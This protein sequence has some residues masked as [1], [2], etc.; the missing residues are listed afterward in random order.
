MF[1]GGLLRI[2]CG[3][4]LAAVLRTDECRCPFEGASRTCG[5]HG[6]ERHVFGAPFLNGETL[7]PAFCGLDVTLAQG[8]LLSYIGTAVSTRMSKNRG[9]VLE[10]TTSNVRLEGEKWTRGQTR[11]K[12]SSIEQEF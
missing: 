9:L 12:P 10:N 5:P 7:S 2:D 11:R 6:A 8:S 4:I 1:L 3:T